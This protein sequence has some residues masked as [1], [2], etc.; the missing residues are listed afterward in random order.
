MFG[1]VEAAARSKI[2]INDNGCSIVSQPRNGTNA[3]NSTICAEICLWYEEFLYG[4]S[5][6][7]RLQ[8][9]AVFIDRL[10][11]LMKD[12]ARGCRD[13]WTDSDLYF[14]CCLV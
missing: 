5:R 6:A 12:G 7:T 4:H 2:V 11:G 8:R 9:F 3:S 14:Y 13:I 10:A 1:Q